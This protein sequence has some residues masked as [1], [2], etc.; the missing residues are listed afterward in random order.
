MHAPGLQA[1][2]DPRFD[3]SL[4]ALAA[5]RGPLA[6]I[7]Q[8]ARGLVVP[9]SYLRF[10]GFEAACARF[11]SQG[12]PVTVRQS[13]GGIVPQ[14]PG[15]INLSLAYQVEGPALRHSEPGYRLICRLL[16]EALA[17]MGVRAFPAP[18]EGSFCDGRYNLAVAMGDTIVKIAGTAQM[19]RRLPGKAERHIGL[20]HALILVDI[21]S[22]QVTERANAFE[23]TLGSERRY[24]P[25]R[26]TALARLCDGAHD[27]EAHFVKALEK[28]VRDM[29][30]LRPTD[31]D[32]P[33]H[34][35][36]PPRAHRSSY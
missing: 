6:S 23:E 7:W 12:W 36:C 17:D 30:A 25:D 33:A 19:W 13:G 31:A 20:V 18:V 11:A 32:R 28:R 3:E 8:M 24:R 34:R 1:C 16:S 14:G 4:V 5:D 15:I 21:D 9:R 29:A 35:R 2:D 26:V 10:D 22:D 27:V